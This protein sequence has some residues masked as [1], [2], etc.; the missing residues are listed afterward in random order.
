MD[1]DS[2]L[3]LLR[4]R[5]ETTFF[6][7]TQLEKLIT[8]ICMTLSFDVIEQFLR[9]C[10]AASLTLEE[11]WVRCLGIMLTR[12]VSANQQSLK[13]SLTR[14]LQQPG[15]QE[16]APQNQPQEPPDAP[17]QGASPARGNQQQRS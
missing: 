15:L 8:E 4:F 11:T 3:R 7:E 10:F 12:H 16:P 13:S 17:D 1:I 6:K 5:R 2:F 14:L 9:A